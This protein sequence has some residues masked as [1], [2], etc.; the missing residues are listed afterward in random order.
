MISYF[1][2]AMGLLLAGFLL[3]VIPIFKSPLL[4]AAMFGWIWILS[5]ILMLTPAGFPY[6]KDVTPQRQNV[7]VGIM[8][9]NYCG[10][11]A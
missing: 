5:V 9:A 10:R 4:V 2:I 11:P 6:A 7:I 3:P 1:A 8:N